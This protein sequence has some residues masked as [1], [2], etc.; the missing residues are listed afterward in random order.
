M[1]SARLDAQ[2]L[3]PDQTD[4][5]APDPQSKTFST[6]RSV[7]HWDEWNHW[8]L[9]FQKFIV[10]FHESGWKAWLQ[11]FFKMVVRLGKRGA[12]LENLNIGIY[13]TLSVLLGEI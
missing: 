8:E 6:N 3:R 12:F 7:C 2:C 5:G 13:S 11:Q 9:G 1:N 10:G 4:C